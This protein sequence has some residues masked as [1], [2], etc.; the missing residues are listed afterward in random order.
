M[1]DQETTSGVQEL[2]DKLS[3]EG[4]AEGE[5]QAEKIVREARQK[6]DDILNA[7]RSQAKEILEHG[8]AEAAQFRAAGE[9]AL[10][11]AARDA[12]RDFGAKVHDGL[13]NRLQELVQHHLKE[14]E[15]IKRMI[16]EI[17]R[18]ATEGLEGESLELLLPLDIITEEEA[19]AAKVSSRRFYKIN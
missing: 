12:V 14:P 11:L 2:I 15:M 13:R 19:R 10:R 6:A 17:T 8:R 4:V 3:Q 7:A 9:E 1:T 5:Q 18:R 16:L